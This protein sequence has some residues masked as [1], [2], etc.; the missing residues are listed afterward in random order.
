MLPARGPCS[1]PL[2]PVASTRTPPSVETGSET[3]RAAGQGQCPTR[4]CLSPRRTP[5]PRPAD[6]RIAHR[7]RRRFRRSR[8]CPRTSAL[9]RPRAPPKLSRRP[10]GLD[11]EEQGQC[12][13]LRRLHGTARRLERSGHHHRRLRRTRRCRSA[14]R[15]RRNSQVVGP[16]PHRQQQQGRCNSRPHPAHTQTLPAARSRPP[17]VGRTPGLRSGGPN[18]PEAGDALAEHTRCH[19]RRPLV[20]GLERLTVGV[21]WR[22]RRLSS[23]ER[24]PRADPQRGSVRDEATAA[25]EVRP[26][27]ASMLGSEFQASGV[28]GILRGVDDRDDR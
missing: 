22:T 16:T 9:R 26:H 4:R 1:G 28:V 18:E 21:C 8:P 3:S 17:G 13:G 14:D 10:S 7:D 20:G 2:R 23:F 15:R 24:P 27:G 5:T 25:D 19:R 12:P 11:R 6:R